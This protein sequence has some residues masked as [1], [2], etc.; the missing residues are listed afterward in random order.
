[1]KSWKSRLW[2]ALFVAIIAGTSFYVVPDLIKYKSF[3]AVGLI[4]NEP[5]SFSNK[6]ITVK[7][8]SKSKSVE[9]IKFKIPKSYMVGW[10]NRKSGEKSYISIDAKLDDLSSRCSSNKKNS[11]QKKQYSLKLDKNDFL[12]K[13]SIGNKVD[14]SN[15][16]QNV[17]TEFVATDQFG[18]D[19][20]QKPYPTGVNQ[21]PIGWRYY[22]KIPST[23]KGLTKYVDC[24]PVLKTRNFSGS[25][26]KDEYNRVMCAGYFN[27]Q[28]E[29]NVQYHFF[30]EHLNDLETLENKAILLI[31]KFKK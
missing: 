7:L 18:Y 3:K 2:I 13:M 29:I 31:E 16:E 4:D 26:H 22:L 20:Y 9:P 14:P 28:N 17:Y 30:H 21:E 23:Y 27:Y 19:L 24:V 15:L 25:V 12:I 10:N 6:K 1:M 11:N 8:V 5:C